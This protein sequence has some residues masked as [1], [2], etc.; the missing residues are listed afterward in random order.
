MPVLE[1]FIVMD[2]VFHGLQRCFGPKNQK[3]AHKLPTSKTLKKLEKRCRRILK[4]KRIPRHLRKKYLSISEESKE[5]MCGLRV[6]EYLVGRKLSAPLI[7]NHELSITPPI[8]LENRRR[9]QNRPL[10]TNACEVLK[11]QW[12]RWWQNC[13]PTLMAATMQITYGSSCACH[14]LVGMYDDEESDPPIVLLMCYLGQEFKKVCKHADM[15]LC[16]NGNGPKYITTSAAMELIDIHDLFQ[17]INNALVEF[18]LRADETNI[19]ISEEA[20]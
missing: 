20:E 15:A 1:L 13:W 10:T 5:N 7:L 16:S 11:I 9:L 3:R 19:N 2:N 17:Q 6:K 8:N 4:G 14:T 12:G 18:L